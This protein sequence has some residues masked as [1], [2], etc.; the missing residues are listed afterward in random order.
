A[1]PGLSGDQVAARIKRVSPV[2][3]VIMLT[4]FG[5]LM[6]GMGEQP[7]GVDAIMSKPITLSALRATLAQCAS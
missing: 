6:H 3:P 5:D 7:A 1:M 4:G 2:T